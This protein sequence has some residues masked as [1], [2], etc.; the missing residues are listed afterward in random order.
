M[1][2]EYVLAHFVYILTV[3]HLVNECDIP[4]IFLAVLEIN[5]SIYF[6]HPPGAEGLKIVHP[7]NCPYVQAY[8]MYRNTLKYGALTGQGA[9]QG[10]KK[11]LKVLN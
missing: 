10:L 6:V 5:I 3:T 7:A 8:I 11:S 4:C 1:T 9:F 2:F